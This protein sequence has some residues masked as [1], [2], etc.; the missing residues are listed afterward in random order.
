MSQ[1]K[2]RR[3]DPSVYK[4]HLHKA[5][6]P[7]RANCAI[8]MLVQEIALAADDW[9][10]CLALFRDGTMDRILPSWPS[11]AE[12]PGVLRDHRRMMTGVVEAA[13]EVLPGIAFDQDFGVMDLL[14]ESR[15]VAP[16]IRANPEEFE[17]QWRAFW[18]PPQAP[19]RRGL[20]IH[21]LVE[22]GYKSNLKRLREEIRGGTNQSADA[23]LFD[24]AL[25]SPELYAMVRLT[26]PCLMQFQTTPIALMRQAKQGDLQ[27]I[28][29]LVRLHPQALGF[30][31]IWQ[32][33]NV[34]AGETRIER[35]RL[36]RRWQTQG[37]DYGQF[38]RSRAKACIGGLI[39]AI[40]HSVGASYCFCTWQRFEGR[41]EH[42]QIRHLL[43][44]AHKDRA[45]RGRTV[46]GVCDED[47][48]GLQDG[49]WAR[50]VRDARKQWMSMM[51]QK[52]PNTTEISH[53]TSRFQ[54]LQSPA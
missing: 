36:V 12:S 41:V 15:A 16:A 3:H 49:T 40:V 13:P 28:E 44:A 7:I 4:M 2:S 1:S 37:L 11:G 43:D 53:L 50:Y 21:R 27:A 14:D 48:A 10:D 52:D 18:G 39:S 6:V 17:R 5:S 33:V 30:D 51:P 24:E 45:G 9:V 20:A 31:F 22:R 34:D 42:G 35:Q 54:V 46:L 32:W 8:L 29:R 38:K 26:L 19:W 25:L 23:K 47:I